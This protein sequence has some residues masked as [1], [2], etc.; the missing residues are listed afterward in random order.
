MPTILI[1][2]A[3]R[4]LGLEFVRQ[5]AAAGWRV[6]ATV[7]DPLSGKAA[8]DAGAEVYVADMADPGSL[9]RLV[10]GLGETGLDVLLAN[11]GLYGTNQDFGAVDAKGFLHVMQVNVLAPLHLAELLADRM[12]RGGIIAAVSSKMGSMTEN[13]SG[14]NYAYRASKAAL[15]MVLKSMSLDLKDRGLTVVAL[16]PGWV[17]TDMGGAAAPLSPEQ[18]VAGMRQV[19]DRVGPEDSGA[20][21]HYDGTKLPW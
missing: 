5:Y 16:S 13:T 1:T 7:R 3:A 21:L 20:F 6:L 2:G 4:G 9:D 14:G 10:A 19:L 12:A 15:N 11:A 17:R 8:S 18:A